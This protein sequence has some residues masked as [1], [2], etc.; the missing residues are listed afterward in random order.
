MSSASCFTE[1]YGHLYE[2]MHELLLV[3]ACWCNQE[4]GTLTTY[5]VA[6]VCHQAVTMHP[7]H[8]NPLNQYD[9]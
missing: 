7:P 8:V 5:R 2:S 1:A 3:L 6:L 9:T 4:D